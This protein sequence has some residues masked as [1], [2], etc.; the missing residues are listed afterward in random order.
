MPP[1]GRVL[2]V[3]DELQVAAMLRD[4]LVDLGYAVKNAM[5][6]PEALQ[7]VPAFRPDVVLLDLWLPGMQ[8]VEILERIRAMEPRLPV[9]IVSA[10]RD[11]DLARGTLARGAFDY[12]AK[13][14][15]VP[16]LERIVAAALSRGAAEGASPPSTGAVGG[17]VLYVEDN[18]SNVLLVERLLAQRP[19]V[20]LLTAAEGRRGLALA[21]EHR[22]DLILLDLHLPDM[23]GEDLLR[24]M[25]E[26]PDVER[27]PVIVLSAEAHVGLPERM[28]AA[29]ARAYLMKPLD[30][31][32][33][34]SSVDTT[35]A[36][37]GGQGPAR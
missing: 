29:G 1:L 8:G 10:N 2:V 18:P 27:I 24:M 13:P 4:V 9:V 25:R 36:A 12:L 28:L 17:T 32:E 22:P 15:E 26:D 35:L 31:D 20:R 3:E 6:G 30:F 37:R 19:G 14:F 7:L 11:I 33:F 34:F 23:E 21:R 5:S 16:V